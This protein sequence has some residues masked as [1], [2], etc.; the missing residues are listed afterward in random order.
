MGVFNACSS[1]AEIMRTYLILT[2]VHRTT[3]STVVSI[4]TAE[5]TRI[6][7]LCWYRDVLKAERLRIHSL[8]ASCLI[9]HS[10]YT[11]F[12]TQRLLTLEKYLILEYPRVEGHW[13]RNGRT[14]VGRLTH[15][16]VDCITASTAV[17]Q[18]LRIRTSRR[19]YAKYARVPRGRPP[20]LLPSCL[21]PA[22]WGQYIDFILS[23]SLSSLAR[24]QSSSSVPPLSPIDPRCE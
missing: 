10:V 16:C 5:P 18:L 21:S 20:R 6:C 4:V 24:S 11:A 19:V 17:T 14:L 8:C 7:R 22:E 1:Q 15:R 3:Q 2:T 13:A 12:W 23:R 9:L